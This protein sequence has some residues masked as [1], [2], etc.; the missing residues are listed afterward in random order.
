[1]NMQTLPT[2]F[3]SML[4]ARKLD[5]RKVT[6]QVYFADDVVPNDLICD[7]VIRDQ[8]GIV[9]AAIKGLTG[10]AVRDLSGK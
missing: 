7:L 6:V 2:G 9:V 4:F 1:M 3:K 8:E 5:L 10:V